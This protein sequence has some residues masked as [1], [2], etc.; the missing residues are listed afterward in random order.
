MVKLELHHNNLASIPP[1]VLE[2]P[3]L[4]DLNVSSNQLVDL[5]CVPEWSPSL[6][7]LDL[8]HNRLT[9]I[10]GSPTAA[11][12]TS[13]NLA[14]NRLADIPPCVLGFA[15]LCT[16]DLKNNN[17]I[18]SESLE[19]LRFHGNLTWCLEDSTDRCHVEGDVPHTLHV[20][21]DIKKGSGDN[22]SNENTQVMKLVL[23]GESGSGK[24]TLASV[25]SGNEG[26][27]GTGLAISSWRLKHGLNDWRLHVNIWDMSEDPYNTTC[28]CFLSEQSICILLFNL[29]ETTS[30]AEVMRTWVERIA[31]WAP[32]AIAIVVGTHVDE[33]PVQQ[34]SA[35][36]DFLHQA[37]NQAA[38]QTTTLQVRECLVVGLK[39]AMESID[40]LKEAIWRCAVRHPMDNGRPVT[41]LPAN[42]TNLVCLGGSIQ[43]TV[44]RGGTKPVLRREEF[45]ELVPWLNLTA[46]EDEDTLIATVGSHLTMA[47]FILHYPNASHNLSDLYFVDPPFLWKTMHQTVRNTSIKNGILLVRHLPALLGQNCLLSE[48]LE[49]Y[50]MLLQDHN[51]AVAVDNRMLLIPSMLAA[52]EPKESDVIGEQGG[53]MYTRHLTFHHPAG[54]SSGTL[55]CFWSQL[56]AHIVRFVP[57][58]RLAFE[59]LLPCL[60]EVDTPHNWAS[61][62][63]L[64]I[65]NVPDALPYKPD[66]PEAKVVWW[67]RG[68]VYRDAEVEFRVELLPNV[69]QRP[70]DEVLIMTSRNPLGARTLGQLV[71]MASRFLISALKGGVQ[72]C[73]IEVK[74]EVPCCICAKLGHPSPYRFKVGKC[75]SSIA[76]NKLYVK[77]KQDLEE[78]HTVPVSDLV[79]DLML[80]DLDPNLVLSVSSLSFDPSEVVLGKGNF[81]TVYHCRHKGASAAVKV[82]HGR[83]RDAFTQLRKEATLLHG[84]R[85]P[86]LVP[87]IGALLHPAMAL[88]MEEAPLGSLDKVLIKRRQQVHRL[89]FHRMAAQVAAAIGFLHTRGVMCCSCKASDVLVWS[90][91]PASLFHCKLGDFGAAKD[92][93]AIGVRSS[94]GVEEFAAPEVL[95]FGECCLYD[96]RADVYSYSMLLYQMVA[97]RGP[98]NGVPHQDIAPAVMRGERPELR[99]V[100]LAETE[101][102]YLTRLMERCWD[103]DPGQRPTTAEAVGLL[104]LP[105]VQSI[106]AVRQMETAHSVHS[107]HLATHLR[108]PTPH[109]SALWV[110]SDGA[111]GVEVT[112][113]EVKT[114]SKQQTYLITDQQQLH[115]SLLTREHLWVCTSTRQ[116]KS[117]LHAFNIHSREL[118]KW[119]TLQEHA[120]CCM[121]SAHGTIHCGTHQGMCLAFDQETGLKCAS[122]KLSDYRVDGLAVVSD[123]LWVSNSCR[124]FLLDLTTLK[125]KVTLTRPEQDLANVG[126]LHPSEQGD[127][128]WSTDMF[129]ST[130]FTSWSKDRR[131]HNFDV[132][133]MACLSR[134][135]HRSDISNAI[136]ALTPA[137][138]TVWVAMATGHILVFHNKE[139]LT[140]FRPY[141]QYVRFLTCLHCE[142]PHSAEQAVVVSG[143]KG[144]VPS[145]VAGLNCAKDAKSS[146]SLEV[147]LVMW[148][149]FPSELCHQ[150]QFVHDNAASLTAG[151]AEMVN[152]VTRGGFNDGIPQPNDVEPTTTIAKSVT[153][154]EEKVTEDVENS[155]DLSCSHRSSQGLREDELSLSR[156]TCPIT[157]SEG[158][159]MLQS[160]CPVLPTSSAVEILEVRLPHIEGAGIQVC[161][162]R[163]V[164]LE[165]LLS[166]L[167]EWQRNN[168]VLLPRSIDDYM[169]S[170]YLP[171]TIESVFMRMQGDLD[172]YLLLMRRPPLILV[173]RTQH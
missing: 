25:L 82:F 166:K 139:M 111:S 121:V 143:G 14:H 37:A 100:P 71:K 155:T 132:D 43:S 90:L 69:D 97:R 4:Q 117:Q 86:C 162:P 9:T 67:Q 151:E 17:A 13:L 42:C 129:K 98:F 11:S 77:C 112:T 168:S 79:P 50:V 127:T 169:L 92:L 47:G 163:P 61:G 38:Q 134:V 118:E 167:D 78:H 48:Y 115:C 36:R 60:E 32:D 114:M 102:F 137:L 46:Q 146:S 126:R 131:T 172:Y 39:G 51:V 148:E 130:C 21:K 103:G 171:D 96:K 63:L 27:T 149:A 142:G 80:H 29:K 141:T 33:L 113:Y 145:M 85:H 94:Q 30:W 164:K 173:R 89:V 109:D 10:S 150:M 81:S 53:V 5:P 157:T 62:Q 19:R 28:H 91:D 88:V 49:Q 35:V 154:S 75:F 34:R 22:N 110:C 95:R 124:I 122:Q 45:K 26:K 170:Y 125:I 52:E 135:D 74:Q 2:L 160:M 3:S 99:D 101:Y 23:L 65:P 68:I 1:C 159:G 55:L 133:A 123:N 40:T 6:T 54:V 15:K 8:S 136:S 156:S 87:L 7:H 44:L 107:A 57:R 158:L 24:T 59:S 105:S 64:T 58:V 106:M 93:E 41:L 153:G 18:S 73:P 147:T 120:V 83:P 108:A 144:F 140:W 76:T 16:L 104:C 128:V 116:G 161:C 84:L 165:L 20:T 31:A 119:I 152:M 66:K 12:L 56:L 72:E 138:D 70:G